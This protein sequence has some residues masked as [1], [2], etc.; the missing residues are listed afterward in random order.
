MGLLVLHVLKCGPSKPK[1]IF[2]NGAED[3]PSSANNECKSYE[4]GTCAEYPIMERKK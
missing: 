2:V 4:T 1:L 3:F